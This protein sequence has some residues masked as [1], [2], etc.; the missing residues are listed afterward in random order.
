MRG[1]DFGE[2]YLV[3]RVAEL[4]GEVTW[5]KEQTDFLAE[6]LHATCVTRSTCRLSNDL[7]SP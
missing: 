3:K 1:G 2:R 7:A 5:P 4:R 6:G